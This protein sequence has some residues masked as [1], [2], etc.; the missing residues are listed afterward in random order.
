M[1]AEILWHSK[2]P[3]TTQGA[4]RYC[5]HVVSG[6]RLNCLRK[7]GTEP[8]STT[9]EIP[10]VIARLAFPDDAR[11]WIVRPDH[12]KIQSM[13]TMVVRQIVCGKGGRTNCPYPTSLEGGAR[14][15]SH[16]IV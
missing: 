13:A 5:T 1:T 10:A 14:T 16:H 4:S 8:L 12:M 7:G 6:D 9:E 15:A 11:S 2:L 3:R